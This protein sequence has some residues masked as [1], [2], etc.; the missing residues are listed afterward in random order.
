MFNEQKNHNYDIYYRY[1][2]RNCLD[3]SD[4]VPFFQPKKRDLKR[5]RNTVDEESKHSFNRRRFRI[6]KRNIDK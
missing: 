6:P 1:F 3:S 5:N 2:R 4:L